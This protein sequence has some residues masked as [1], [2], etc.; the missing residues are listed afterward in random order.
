MKQLGRFAVFWKQG[1]R[2]FFQKEV[3]SILLW[4]SLGAIAAALIRALISDHS[5]DTFL[6]TTYLPPPKRFDEPA[7]YVPYLLTGAAAVV[8]F[9]LIRGWRIVRRGVKS[10]ILGVTS[11]LKFIAFVSTVALLNLT[12]YSLLSRLL[13]NLAVIVGFL[14]AACILRHLAIRRNDRTPDESAVRVNAQKND[15]DPELTATDD[16]ITKW[17]ED[18]VGRAPVV[19]GLSRSILIAKSPV[20]ALFG[21]FGSGK[22]SILNLLREHLRN[23]A[24][25]VSFSSWLPGSEETL[26]SYLMADIAN[27]CDKEYM[28]PGL[29]RSATRLATALA[30][31]VPLLRGFADLIP[32][33]TQ[34]DDIENLRSALRRLPKRVIVLLDEMDRMETDELRTLLKVIRGISQLPNLTFVCAAEQAMLVKLISGSLSDRGS[35]YYEKFFPVQVPVPP[36]GNVELQNAGTDR[37][38]RV[39]DRRDWFESNADKEAFRKKINEVWA[40]RIRPFC[41]TLRAIG[42]LANDV[43]VAAAS[44]VRELDQIDLVLLEV[45]RR[46]KPTV[47]EI[48]ADN[49]VTLT[50][51]DSWIRGGTYR[52]DA[53]KGKLANQLMGELKEATGNDEVELDYVKDILCEMFP[54]FTEIDGRPLRVLNRQRTKRD[55]EDKCIA[56]ADMFPAYFRYELPDAVY[57]SVEFAAFVQRFT[58]ASDDSQRLTFFTDELRSMEKGSVKRDDFLKKVSDEV[59]TANLSTARFWTFAALVAAN[60][61]AYERLFFSL[62]EAAHV[63]RMVLRLALRL[64]K[65]ERAAF[66]S[67]CIEKATDDTMALRIISSLTDPK[68]DGYVDVSFAE[69]YPAF[70]KRMRRLYGRDVNAASV[71]LSTSETQ[72]FNLWGMR[73]LSKH[74]VQPNPEDREIEHD[75][76]RRYIGQSKGRLVRTFNEILMPSGIYDG[77]PEPFVENKMSVD[78]IRKLFT[79]LPDDFDS[80][81]IPAKYVNRLKRFLRG[82][83]K[84][85]IGIEDIDNDGILP[86]NTNGAPG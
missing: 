55:N 31:S 1:V 25:V 15:D 62:G 40:D 41:R 71:D 53:E 18:T 37:L 52:S 42:L 47:Y 27:E 50:G 48:V 84:K 79:E 70:I 51:G 34:R 21:G 56:R 38:V 30:R 77:D 8:V 60:E 19:E 13:A 23:T 45:L 85:G 12:R 68:S 58:E 29:R 80:R 7:R 66:L 26:A 36:L 73:D 74:D 17:E 20:V 59:Q 49:S 28:V 22:T 44:L 61:V 9:I 63:L 11:G 81:E 16:P 86:E 32:A 72:A 33:S 57:S 54:K 35:S 10:W 4:G 69:L 14:L 6:I 67:G 5:F 82:D 78:L 65:S 46:F 3:L 76:W 83:F 24:I 2:N 64:P 39:F 75:F 43:D